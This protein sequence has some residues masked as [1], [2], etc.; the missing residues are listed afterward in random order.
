MELMAF[1]AH[2][3]YCGDID[4]YHNYL[5][6]NYQELERSVEYSHGLLNG[7]KKLCRG[8]GPMMSKLEHAEL[9]QSISNR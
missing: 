8:L 1:T 2:I 5:S 4:M 3:G 9:N 7:M 6:I